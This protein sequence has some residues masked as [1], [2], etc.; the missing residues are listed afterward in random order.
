MAYAPVLGS[1]QLERSSGA[2]CLCRPHLHSQRVRD[3][4]QDYVR[5]YWTSQGVQSNM[6]KPFLE[7]VVYQNR[8][9]LHDDDRPATTFNSFESS[10]DCDTSQDA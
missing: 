7:H 4:K 9:S 5:G 2:A 8:V 1:N 6:V 3:L 10:W